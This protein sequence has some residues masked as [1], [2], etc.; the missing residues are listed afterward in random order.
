MDEDPATFA[1]A[2]GTA[3]TDKQADIKQTQKC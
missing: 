1:R 3:K 2:L